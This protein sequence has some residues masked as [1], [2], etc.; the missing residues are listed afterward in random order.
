MIVHELPQ[1][2]SYIPRFI[3][4]MVHPSSLPLG[5]FFLMEKLFHPLFEADLSNPPY[6]LSPLSC[7]FH[8]FPSLTFF[9][10]CQ[11]INM[12]AFLFFLK[13]NKKHLP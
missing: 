5:L 3:Y 8:L 9:F 12:E 4:T 7:F 1:L 2:L 13:Q 6:K 10:S 11:P